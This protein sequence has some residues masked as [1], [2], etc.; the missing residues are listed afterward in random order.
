MT[1]PAT[2]T[3][4]AFLAAY[5]A[6]LVAGC[7]WTVKPDVLERFMTTVAG[8]IAGSGISW[9]PSG[10]RFAVTAWRQIGGKGRLTLKALR[11]LPAD[12]DA[13]APAAVPSDVASPPARRAEIKLAVA[14][15]DEALAAMRLT[16]P[17]LPHA[18]VTDLG[19]RGL[20]LVIAFGA[21]PA[22]SGEHVAQTLAL[23]RG[24]LT[25]E[26]AT[27]RIA[28]LAAQAGASVIRQLREGREAAAAQPEPAP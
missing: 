25:G 16:A 4:A 26:L 28:D 21:P 23:L 10:Q 14:A 13:P 12:A 3:R 19:A 1:A 9:S 8:A 18:Q 6:A 27:R 2:P 5:R 7:P 17:P 22:D 11:A 24:L 15:I 20:G